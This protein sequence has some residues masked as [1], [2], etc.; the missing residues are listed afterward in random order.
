[1]A[2]SMAEGDTGCQVAAPH[3]RFLFVTAP[4][5]QP[6]ETVPMSVEVVGERFLWTEFPPELAELAEIPL[7]LLTDPER[8]DVAGQVFSIN[9]FFSSSF[10]C[11]ALTHSHAS[12]AAGFS[13]AEDSDQ[14]EYLFKLPD[15]VPSRFRYQHGQA[16]LRIPNRHIVEKWSVPSCTQRVIDQFSRSHQLLEFDDEARAA[17]LGT[18]RCST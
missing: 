6:R 3:D 17:F 10:S 8:A 18:R 4:R 9:F 16:F 15:G 7:E 14:D 13:K 11:C 12:P 1:M 2:M 5:V